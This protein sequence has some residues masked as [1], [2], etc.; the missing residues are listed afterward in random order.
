MLSLFAKKSAASQAIDL[1]QAFAARFAGRTLIVH[2]G[3]SPGWI[4]ELQREGGGGAHFRIDVRQRPA[5]PLTPVE[6]MVRRHI[7]PLAC[8]LPLLV[9]VEPDC[10]RLRHLTRSGVPVHPSEIVWM[11]EELPQRAHWTLHGGS[12]GWRAERGMPFSDNRIKFSRLEG[13]G[14]QC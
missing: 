9:K 4:A 6:W 13:E 10:L 11:L 7:L 1:E 14:G 5:G 2:A 8:P 3:L 12:G